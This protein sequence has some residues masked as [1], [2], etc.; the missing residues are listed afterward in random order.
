M[1]LIVSSTFHTMTLGELKVLV[2]RCEVMGMDD[3]A[4]VR[5]QVRVSTKT[6][7]QV[8]AMAVDDGED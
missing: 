6:H 7:A 8:K 3:S 2:H 4:E 5:A 1:K